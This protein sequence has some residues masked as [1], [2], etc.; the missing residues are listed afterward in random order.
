MYGIVDFEKQVN[1][2]PASEL[3][4]HLSTEL[5]RIPWSQERE[6]FMPKPLTGNKFVYKSDYLSDRLIEQQ[7]RAQAFQENIL[8]K[9]ILWKLVY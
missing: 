4:P 9:F 3:T 8:V 1:E 6:E 5:G 2:L 7:E